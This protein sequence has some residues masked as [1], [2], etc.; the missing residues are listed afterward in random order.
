MLDPAHPITEL[1][2]EDSRDA[3]EA[4]VFLFEALGYAQNVLNMGTESPSEETSQAEQE[5]EEEQ[6]AE[7]HV[8]GQDLCEAVRRCAVEQYGY[9]AKTVLNSWGVTKTDVYVAP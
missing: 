8:T 3:F 1:L 5:S 4:Y 6:V 2:K 9:M 7:R